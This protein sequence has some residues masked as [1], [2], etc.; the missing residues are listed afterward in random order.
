MDADNNF[1]FDRQG[2]NG[3]SYIAAVITDG[4]FGQVDWTFDDTWRFAP[5]RQADS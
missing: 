1:V 5:N 4:L 2:T 3:E